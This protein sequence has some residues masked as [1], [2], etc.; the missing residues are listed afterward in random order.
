M[1]QYH[2][3]ALMYLIRQRDR[4]A[5]IKL[6]QGFTKN[7]LR[8]PHAQCML[9]RY[10]VKVL[11]E[12]DVDG[13]VSSLCFKFMIFLNF[14]FLGHQSHACRTHRAHGKLPA[15][16]KRYCGV[17]S[18]Q[19]HL[20]HEECH[21]QG[22]HPRRFGFALPFTIFGFLSLSSHFIPSQCSSSS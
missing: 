2:A 14:C 8:S 18:C 19:V 6:V 10:I 15:P 1:V 9:I 3:L 4:M 21:Q 17:R 16:Q 11:E 12:D 13:W 20:L 22:A 7:P 5:V